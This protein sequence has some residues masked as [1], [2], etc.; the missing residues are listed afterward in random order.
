LNIKRIISKF[1]KILGIILGVI[2]LLIVAVILFVRSPW[3]QD[4]IVGKATSYV[5]EKTQTKVEIERL[6]ITF[7]GNLYLEGLFLD[8]QKGDTLLYSKNLETGLAI[9]PLIS[10]GDIQVTKLEWEGLVANVS[11]DSTS[12]EFNFDFLINAFVA[13][14]DELSSPESEE[15]QSEASEFPNISLGPIDLEDFRLKYY[16]EVLGIDL[17]ASWKAIRF[18]V[19]QL[20]L[21]KMNFDVPEIAVLGSAIDYKQFKPFPPAEE[22]ETSSDMPLPLL[23]LEKLSIQ[24]AS[25]NYHSIPDGLEAD[26]KIG[27]FWVELPEAD[28]ESQK[29]LLKSI[30]LHESVIALKLEAQSPRPNPTDTPENQST[31]FE[32]PDWMVEL[33]DLDFENNSLSY[34]SGDAKAQRGVFNADNIA[35]GELDLKAHS[36]FLKDQKAGLILDKFTFTEQSGLALQEFHFDF[37]IEK[38]QLTIADFSVK[39]NASMLQANLSLNYPSIDA[40]IVHPELSSIDLNIFELQTDASEALFFSPE[41]KDEFYFSELNKNGL[42]ANGRLRGTMERLELP[43]FVLNYGDSTRLIVERLRMADFMDVDK[44]DFDL[45]KLRFTSTQSKLNPWLKAFELDYDIPEHISLESKAKGNI[46]QMVADVVLETTDGNMYLNVDFKDTERISLDSKLTLDELDLGKILRMPELKPISLIVSASGEGKDLY[47]LEGKLDT[48]ISHL[49]WG[50]YDLS[51]LVF[52]IEAKDTTANLILAVDKEI[53]DVS[54]EAFAKLDTLQPELRFKLDLRNMETMALGLT[55][56]DITARIKMEGEVSGSMDDLSAKINFEDGFL[57]YERQAYPIGEIDLEARLADTITSLK[58]QSDFLKGE[59]EADGS[60]ELLTLAMQQYFEELVTGELDSVAVEPI[61]AKANFRFIPTPF[62]D[63]LL[64]AGIEELDTMNLDFEFDSEASR[65]QAQLY[66]PSLEY[67]GATI[68]SFTLEMDGDAQRLSLETGYDELIYGPLDMGKTSLSG[69]FQANDIKILFR[70]LVDEE[71]IINIASVL[72]LSGDTLSYH[73]DPENL[74]INSRA[75]NVKENNAVHYAEN[76]LQFEDFVFTRNN[77][78]LRLS[79]DILSIE[80]EHLGVVLKEFNLSTL[81]SFLNPEEPLVKGFANGEMVVVNPFEALGVIADLKVSELEVFEIALGDLSLDA[82][83]KTLRDYD[84]NLTLKEGMIDLDLVGEIQASEGSSNLDLELSLNQLQMAMLEK[85]A[86][87][88]IR[89]TDGYISGNVRLGGSFQEPQYEGELNFNN[90][91]LV[92]SQLNNKFSVSDETL[93]IDNSGLYFS[94][95]EIADESGHKFSIDGKIDTDDFSA[96]GLD[97]KLR[98]DDFQVLNSTR[99]DNDLFFGRANV[100]L[101]MDVKGTTDLPEI[102]VKLRINRATN[103]TLIIPESQLELVEKSG[104]VIF[105]NHADPYDVLNKRETEISTRG[106]QGYNVKA[107]LQID[108]QATFNVIV[109]ERTGD[110]LRLQGEAD[111]NMIMNPNGDISLSGRYEVNSGHY[112]LNLYNLVNR[113]F[114]LAQGSSIVWNGDPLDANLNLRAIYNVRTSAAEL[115]QAQLSGSDAQTRGQFRQVLRFQVFLNIGGELMQ[116][117]ISFDLDIV[118]QD[119]GAFGGA[120]YSMVQQINENE[121]EVTKQVFALLVLNQFFPTMGNDGSTGGSVN[122]ARSS[123]SQV[124]STQLNA[125]SDRLFGESGFSLDVDLDSFTDYQNGGPED[126]TQLNVAARQSLFDERLIISVGGQMNVEGGSREEMGQGDA[127]FGDV[128]LEYLLDK[129]GQ[130][131]AKAYRRNQFESVID[132]QLIVT[133]ISF[134]F[135][136]EFNA[137]RELWKKREEEEELDPNE[138]ENLEDLEEMDN[139]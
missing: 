72:Q 123:V 57:Y 85:L 4:I 24:N 7:S 93:K 125:L 33:G 49:E 104:V 75:W 17:N 53:L 120:V 38:E 131:R 21:N 138:L 47:D 70:S 133:G 1:F 106:I 76:Y 98:S 65:L 109:D 39:T 68:K 122:I 8:D 91:S 9:R 94:T 115:M 44:L 61:K 136:R 28:L 66:L 96:I 22:E 12:G 78:E 86:G 6:F 18:R 101:D 74:I 36:I 130:W 35:F 97:L 50:T 110:N 34:Q 10:S 139:Q 40:L 119:R 92:V 63:Q 43:N 32:W 2:L 79:N 88:E 46:N 99:E 128:S 29:V 114:E 11:R 60:V 127:L 14:D 69:T 5:S 117:E 56:Q 84:F 58:L 71:P 81:T 137:F 108:P 80:E 112:E 3:G 90:T 103:F 67:T 105:V 23:V 64:L 62:I 82:Q 111:L 27:D 134:I 59:A 107:N 89:N 45:E 102:D 25:W 15:A 83:A 31:G 116:P 129:N 121:D 48:E 135:N 132:G 41:L 19:E 30:G 95:F 20:D 52:Q 42:K 77:Q 37:L 51:D 126:R 26:L 124:L 113:R 100:D 55:D 16:D 13:T 73:V 87:E 54:L 118:E